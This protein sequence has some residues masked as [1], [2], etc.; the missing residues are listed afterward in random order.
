MGSETNKS[1]ISQATYGKGHKILAY[2]R[3]Q[4]GKVTEINYTEM[5]NEKH[6]RTF[7]RHEKEQHIAKQD[8]LTRRTPKPTPLFRVNV[9]ILGSCWNIQVKMAVYYFF[10]NLAMFF[11][12]W[13]RFSHSSVYFCILWI[14]PRSKI[15]R[16]R[17][18]GH[19]CFPVHLL[20]L[21]SYFGS[22]TPI[23]AC[24]KSWE[25]Y[26]RLRVISSSKLNW[27]VKEWKQNK[28][29]AFGPNLVGSSA[30]VWSNENNTSSIPRKWVHG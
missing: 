15:H 27:R 26:E 30:K 1:T 17:A 29:R 2:G 23:P 11:A 10:W 8:V 20:S 3:R 25:T 16:L 6:Q 28:H 18:F 24:G 5:P 14:L 13:H 9:D 21:I 7:V 12:W 4:R 19:L 22:S